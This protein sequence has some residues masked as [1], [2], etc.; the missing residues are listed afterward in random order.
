MEKTK[1]LIIIGN[2]ETAEI[3]YEYFTHDSS[4]EVAGFSVNKEFLT[5]S[6]FL[7]L[8]VYDF[9]DLENIIS[10]L[11]S[12]VYVAIS[13]SKLNRSRAKMYF[14][15]KHKGFKCANYISSKAFVWNSV[16][17]GDNVFV[18]ENNVLQH[19]VVLG[20]NI[21]LWSGNHIG[22]RT[23]IRDH[24][25]ISS[26]CVVAGFCDIGSYSFL[27]VNCTC[28]DKVKIAKDNVI[29][30]GALIWKDT[31]IGKVMIGSPAIPSIQSS[32]DTFNILPEEV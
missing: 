29:G 10:P 27:G 22:H 15:A 23:V 32:Y 30:S 18:F 28:N 16:V 25:F 13:H 4:Y 14:Q 11:E 21:T 26:Q 1:K 24:V 31:I 7:R 17:F 3:A 6:T 20:N 12:E 19:N 8:P 5:Q 2:G 9:D